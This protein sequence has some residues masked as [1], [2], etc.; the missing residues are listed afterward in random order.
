VE[1]NYELHQKIFSDVGCFEN[2]RCLFVMGSVR[3]RTRVI[4]Q[5]TKQLISCRGEWLF[6]PTTKSNFQP[7]AHYHHSKGRPMCLPR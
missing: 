2:I 3:E 7:N 1:A 5:A 6:V 4:S